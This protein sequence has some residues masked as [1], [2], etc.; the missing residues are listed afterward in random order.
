MSG[1]NHLLGQRLFESGIVSL[2]ELDLALEEQ[3]QSRK[4]LGVILLEKGF[5]KEEELFFSLL[6]EHIRCGYVNLKNVVIPPEIILKI[7]AQFATHYK[8]IPVSLENKTLTVAT[9]NPFDQSLREGIQI[10]WTGRIRLVMASEQGVN[11]AIRKYY[12]LGAETIDAMMEG[13]PAARQERSRVNDVTELDSEASITKFLNQILLEAY[14]KRA[15]DIHIEPFESDLVIRY[16]IDGTLTDVQAPRNI[17]H[18]RDAI[19]SR[20]KIMSNL[21][22]AER[23]LPQDG[24]L[25][26]RFGGTDL[27]LRVSFLPTQNGE[28]IVIRLLT[29]NQLYDLAQLGL[30]DRDLKIM[31]DLIHRP[32]GIIFASGPTGSGKT[33]TLYCCLSQLNNMSKKIITIE[34]PVEYLMKG[35]IQLQVNPKIGFTFA[36]G[37]RSMLRHDPDIMMVGEVRDIETA[38]TAIQ[39]ALT[40]HLVF[41]TLHTNDAVGGL[42]RLMDMGLEPYLVSSSVEAF[43]AQRLVK[44]ICPKC[45]KETKVNVKNLRELGFDVSA[46]AVVYEGAGCEACQFSG[47]HGRE[48]IFEILVMNDT[49]REMVVEKSSAGKIKGAALHSGMTPLLKSGWEKIKAGITTVNEVVR[50]A[51][52]ELEE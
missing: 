8:A 3:K 52:E 30:C 25:K 17:W 36:S 38:E 29:S 46:D 12:G 5:V 2:E 24:R 27:D 47:Y 31:K 13:V 44:R 42:T 19:S 26:A 1:Q 7:P 37:L 9:P 49:I 18:F 28:S 50:V 23:R 20:I 22:I 15:T 40:G 11:A 41:S 10:M 6:A 51:R 33:T 48:G 34:D 32:H 43:I 4:L 21:N 14:Q 35:V 16:R 39:V 45:K